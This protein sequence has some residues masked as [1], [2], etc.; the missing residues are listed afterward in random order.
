MIQPKF[1]LPEFFMHVQ[2]PRLDRASASPAASGGSTVVPPMLALSNAP[3]GA[4]AGAG[5]TGR[6]DQGPGAPR[7]SVFPLENLLLHN[8]V[9]EQE[10]KSASPGNSKVMYEA[11]AAEGIHDPLNAI[12]PHQSLMRKQV[13]VE[14]LQKAVQN[15]RGE[16]DV[17]LMNYVKGLAGKLEL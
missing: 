15:F 13:I 1:V 11:D 2:F 7:D 16:H 8:A 6:R 10:T 3:S 14:S 9:C 12:N 17:A 5:T 4:A